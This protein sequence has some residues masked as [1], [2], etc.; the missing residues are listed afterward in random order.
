VDNAPEQ[1]GANSKF[2]KV[3]RQYKIQ[4]HQTEPYTPR[5]NRAELGIRE[6][7]KKWRIRMRQQGVPHWLWDFGLVWASEIINRMARGPQQRTPYEQIM[8]NTPN[9]SEWLDLS[10]YD[11]CWFWNVPTHKLTEDKAD[12]GRIL[13]IA[14]RV[15]SDMYYWV[16]TDTGQVLARTT[17]QRVTNNNLQVTTIQERMRV[18][19]QKI[20]ECL[21][22]QNHVI[23]TPVEGLILDDEVEDANDEPE[24]E[25]QP[26]QDDYTDDAFNAYLGAALLIP[27]GDSYI[28]GRVTKRLRDH[29]G[30]PIGQ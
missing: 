14:H 4:H 11:W 9:I 8:G 18:Y 5:Q 10:F 19:T 24:Q 1:T 23:T 28:T 12:I 29:D 26:E 3:C 2:L 15:G 20:T 25:T 13:G 17:I 6:I 30:N 27:H 21:D 22:D 16:L 7:K